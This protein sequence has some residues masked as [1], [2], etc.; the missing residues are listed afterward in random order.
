MF[1]FCLLAQFF[2]GLFDLSGQYVV[3]NL[4]GSDEIPDNHFFVVC[5]RDVFFYLLSNGRI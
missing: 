1:G 4:N 2:L 5:Y 3:N